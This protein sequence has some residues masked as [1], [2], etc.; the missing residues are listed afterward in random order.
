MAQSGNLGLSPD[1]RQLAFLGIGDD[2]LT[3]LFIRAMD[4]L[5]VKPLLGSEVAAY[6]PPFFWSPDSRAIA[7]DAG[8]V[9]KK[10]NVAGGPA[11]TLCTLTAGAIGGSW[12]SRGDILVGNLEGGILR[13]PENGGPATLATT[14]DAARKEVSHLLPTFLPDGR[15]FVYIRVSRDQP[16]SGGIFVGSLDAKPEEQSGRRLLPYAPGVTYAPARDGSIGRLLFVREGTLMAQPFDEQRLDVAGDAVPVAEQVGA[17][18]DTA[19]FSTSLNGM[20]VYRTSDPASPIAWFDRQG[21]ALG[22]ISEPGLYGSLALAPDGTQLMASRTNPRDRAGADLWLFDLARNG[23]AT[24]FTSGIFSS[25][26][27]VW[28]PDGKRVIYRLFGGSAL[29]TFFDKPLNDPADQRQIFVSGVEIA[30]PLSWS[31]DGRVLLY[32]S[33]DRVTGWDLWVL[34]A[35][36]SGSNAAVT[37]V[38]FARTKFNEEQGA[39]SPDGRWIAYVSNESGT[40]EVY[41]TA[42]PKDFGNGSAGGG[43][44]VLVSKGGGTS[45]RWRP[46]GRELFYLAS[47]GRLMAI[48]VPA[49]EDL[50]PATPTP[51]FQTPPNAIIGGVAADGKRFVVVQSGVSPFTVVMNWMGH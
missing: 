31:S 19:F 15:H 50:R 13:V 28:A 21:T 17:Y 32:A 8:G 3:R 25:G 34:P 44:R 1:G 4:S 20:L 11:D 33:V 42:F 51:L 48:D 5:E 16:E 18:L 45:P 40:N 22:R 23:S 46:D 35:Q 26:F 6:G 39:F 27:P 36:A 24:R 49:G 38:A 47:D 7:F 30:K 12:N 14:L 2:G 10:M 9:L 37:P 29:T 43:R 41:V